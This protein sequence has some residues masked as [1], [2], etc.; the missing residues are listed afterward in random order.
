MDEKQIEILTEVIDIIKGIDDSDVGDSCRRVSQRKIAEVLGL[1]LTNY[2]LLNELDIKPKY[3]PESYVNE[4][5]I[6]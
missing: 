5:T 2:R 1:D 3:Y 6:E 4:V